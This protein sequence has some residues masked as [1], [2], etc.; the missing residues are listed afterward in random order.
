MDPAKRRGTNG[1]RPL[2]PDAPVRTPG[3]FETGRRPAS[4]SPCRTLGSSTLREDGGPEG[5]GIGAGV[6]WHFLDMRSYIWRRIK[7]LLEFGEIVDG[8][9]R[10]QRINVGAV[11]ARLPEDAGEGGENAC[12]L[13]ESGEHQ[14]ALLEGE[15]SL[16]PLAQGTAMLA[17]GSLARRGRRQHAVQQGAKE[18]DI[19]GGV[20]LRGG[21]QAANLLGREVLAVEPRWCREDGNGGR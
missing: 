14:E 5:N 6:S 19:A 20:S 2:S 10:Q 4:S 21:V 1:G 11:V 8:E 9:G 3:I 13:A 16:R 15:L 18:V 12:G 7:A 17:C